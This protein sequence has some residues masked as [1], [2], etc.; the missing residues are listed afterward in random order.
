NFHLPWEETPIHFASAK[1]SRVWDMNGK[2]YLDLYARFGAQILGHGN[3]EYG[4]ALKETIDRVLSVSHSDMDYQALEVISKHIPSAEMIRFGLSGTEIVQ[5]ALRLARA[6]TGK[7]RFIRFDGHYHGNYDNI[8]G[9]K[10]HD[11]EN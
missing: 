11:V 1:G 9:G 8:M 3:A 6:W 5:N 4:N 10:V 2:E 7:N